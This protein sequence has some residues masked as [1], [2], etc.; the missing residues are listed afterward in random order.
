[1]SLTYPPSLA[2]LLA[3]GVAC[4]LNPRYLYLDPGLHREHVSTLI[5][6]VTT[7]DAW[8]ETAAH[9]GRRYR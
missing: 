8:R 5:C 9:V 6:M 7:R 1:M 2:G 3:L 4:A